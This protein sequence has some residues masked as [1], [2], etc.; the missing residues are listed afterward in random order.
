M[1]TRGMDIQD[2]TIIKKG[3][4]TFTMNNTV[5]YGNIKAVRIQDL[6]VKQIVQDNFDKRPIYF[7]ASS[8]PIAQIGMS[9]Y[10]K[11]EGMASRLVPEKR[12][13]PNFLNEPA[14]KKELLEE[15]KS[16]SKDFQRGFKFRGLNN[17]DIF[18][19]NDQQGM[20]SV[21]RNAFLKLAYH[22]LDTKQNNEAITVLDT[23]MN[24][25]SKN[26][27]HMDYENYARIGDLYFAVG[28]ENKFE[29]IASEAE[30]EASQALAENPNDLTALRVLMNIY[31][32]KKDNVKLLDLWKRIERLYPN[33]PNVKLNIQKYQRLVDSLKN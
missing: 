8:S 26:T 16:Y 18:F 22:Y 20:A 24:K 14:L 7:A 21:Y 33:D 3:S 9:D 25:V 1:D 17:P 11:F 23:M 6:V 28:D 30:P 13:S 2:S 32:N 29:E 4:F 10:I 15:N 5:T 31:Q 19:D 12:T 27:I